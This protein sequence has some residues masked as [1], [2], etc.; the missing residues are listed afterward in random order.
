MLNRAG[1]EARL[2][3]STLGEVALACQQLA[4][5]QPGDVAIN[6]RGFTGYVYLA[7]V[8]QR[9]AHF[10][11]RCSTGSFLAVQELFRR[12]R[13]HQSQVVWLFAPADQLA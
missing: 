4:R 5:L 11:A 9:G 12:N 13:A 2:E 8:R 3:P 7:L 10:M 1:W 6:D